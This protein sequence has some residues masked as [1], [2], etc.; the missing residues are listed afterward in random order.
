MQKVEAK[1]G[2]NGDNILTSLIGCISRITTFKW[3]LKVSSFPEAYFSLII[4]KHFRINLKPNKIAQSTALF[5]TVLNQWYS[6]LSHVTYCQFEE[7][8][9]DHGN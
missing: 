3:S 8:K 4:F 5:K 9:L 7:A 6:T 2:Q 1:K